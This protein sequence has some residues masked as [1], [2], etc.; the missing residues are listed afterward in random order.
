MNLPSG[1]E[2]KVCRLQISLYGLKQSPRAWSERFKKAV[3]GHC[4]KM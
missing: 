1:F 3:K 2:N 4:G